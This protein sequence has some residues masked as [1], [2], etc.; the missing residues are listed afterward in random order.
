[1]KKG[2]YIIL[3]NGNKSVRVEGT[4]YSIRTVKSKYKNMR[5]KIYVRI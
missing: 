1:M 4:V 2:D 3:T 5:T